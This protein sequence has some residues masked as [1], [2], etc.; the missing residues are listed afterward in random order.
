[1]VLTALF[2]GGGGEST[3]PMEAEKNIPW[4]I[5]LLNELGTELILITKFHILRFKEWLVFVC[6]GHLDI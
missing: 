3:A 6:I 5:G 4:G 1:M 2:K